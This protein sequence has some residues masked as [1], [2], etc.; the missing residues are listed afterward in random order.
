M[1][2]VTY[3]GHATVLVELDGARFLTDPV[4]RDRIAYIWRIAPS[5]PA[6]T[7]EGL[8]AVLISHAHHDHLDIPSLRRVPSD[9]PVIAPPG[10]AKVIR[11]KTGHEVIEAVPGTRVPVGDADVLAIPAEHEGR[12][13]PTD[14]RLETLGFVIGSRVAFFGDT[15]LFDEMGDLAGHARRRAAADL[16]LGPARR[17]RSPQPE[18]AARAAALLRPRT[19]VP[20]HWGTLARPLVWW[21]AR[22]GDA[23]R[24]V[25]GAGRRARAG[26]RGARP[27]A[28]RADGPRL[29]RRRPGL[30]F[31]QRGAVTVVT[32]KKPPP[33]N[34]EPWVAEVER[35]RRERRFAD[36]W[37]M[38]ERRDLAAFDDEHASAALVTRAKIATEHGHYADAEAD[39]R[40]AAERCTQKSAADTTCFW[41][42][43]EAEIY[44]Y[45]DAMGRAG[46]P[47]MVAADVEA[48]TEDLR[49][50]AKKGPRGI[51]FHAARAP[52]EWALGVILAG[53]HPEDD[54]APVAIEEARRRLGSAMAGSMGFEEGRSRILRAQARLAWVAARVADDRATAI[55]DARAELQRLRAATNDAH[56]QLTI[57]YYDARVDMLARHL[58]EAR[59]KLESILEHDGGHQAALVWHL[60]CRRVKNGDLRSLLP[61]LDAVLPPTGDEP[62]S[63]RRPGSRG[64]STA[65]SSPSC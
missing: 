40:A 37:T 61:E 34:Q 4:L 47:A 23:G 57:D 52:Y 45:L 53:P 2:S 27:L 51:M 58:D 35:L 29:K 11:Q 31:P 21:R 62:S 7:V 16:G 64:S 3:V 60:Y 54:P 24:P 49:R 48:I 22:A 50:L 6:D 32:V 63:R 14:S 26:R 65:T 59:A 46:E 43:A 13:L 55:R 8:D 36:A 28:G 30:G 39:Y 25:R 41:L 18:R 44:G 56:V 38:L 19:V 10:C 20:I 17:A 33:R 9:V 5:P 12:R 15:D 1:G 42:H